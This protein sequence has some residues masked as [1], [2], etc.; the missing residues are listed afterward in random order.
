MDGRHQGTKGMEMNDNS[1]AGKLADDGPQRDSSD[2][3]LFGD[4]IDRMQDEGAPII[5]HDILSDDGPT[6]TLVRPEDHEEFDAAPASTESHGPAPPTEANSAD[7][8]A[9]DLDAD[10]YG[11]LWLEP[12]RI[13]D[14]VAPPCAAK[15]PAGDTPISESFESEFDE[16]VPAEAEFLGEDHSAVE[17]VILENPLGLT[18]SRE[19]AA[20][21]EQL[22]PVAQA[23]EPV[24]RSAESLGFARPAPQKIGSGKLNAPRLNWKPGDP[25]GCS[26]GPSGPR[27]RWEVMLTTASIT[28][29]CGLGAIWLLRTILA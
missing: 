29:V 17:D 2:L 1:L 25:F 12:A 18:H 24:S 22:M 8:F 21:E 13:D 10:V 6:L 19:P 26:D 3:D 9:A 11:E 16:P 14:N 15:S 28:A 27:F 5:E 23:T 20:P 7:S 4:A